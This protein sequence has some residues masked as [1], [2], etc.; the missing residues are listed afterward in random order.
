MSNSANDS[1]ISLP[2]VDTMDAY[3]QEGMDLLDTGD[4]SA[5]NVAEAITLQGPTDLILSLGVSDASLR[6]GFTYVDVTA[7]VQWQNNGSEWAVLLTLLI[8]CLIVQGFGL[9]VV[10]LM[11]VGILSLAAVEV[12]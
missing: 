1:D 9:L 4:E 6:V 7:R 10:T 12:I 11:P 3:G 5:T 8:C 2:L